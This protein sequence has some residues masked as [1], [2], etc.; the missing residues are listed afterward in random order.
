MHI[1][2]VDEPVRK[3]EKEY[4]FA[5]SA[6]QCLQT[7]TLLRCRQRRYEREITHIRH[8]KIIFNNRIEN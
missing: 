3:S 2:L 7:N 1:Y 6:F 5:Y 8:E 4:T